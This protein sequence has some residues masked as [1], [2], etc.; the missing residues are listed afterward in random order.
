MISAR[1]QCPYCD[2]HSVTALDQL[3][4]SPNVNY[5]RC[6]DCNQLWHVERGQDGPPSQYLLGS[7]RFRAA[8]ASR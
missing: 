5:F 7:R 3:L 4:Y 8:A 2:G 6:L 1:T